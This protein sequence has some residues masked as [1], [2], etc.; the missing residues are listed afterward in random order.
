MVA[1][2]LV[3][4]SGLKLGTVLTSPPPRRTATPV[5]MLSSEVLSGSRGIRWASLL[6]FLC[7]AS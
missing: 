4:Q 7:W 1:V 3:L 2:F 6:L 5:C